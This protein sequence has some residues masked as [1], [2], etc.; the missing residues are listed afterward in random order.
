M[1]PRLNKQI[2][3]IIYPA[4]TILVIGLS[5]LLFVQ[6]VGFVSKKMA[7]IFD[8]DN[9]KIEANLIKVDLENYKIAS[10]RLNLIEPKP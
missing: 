4:I 1:N 7:E 9:M 2:K 6:S 8:V 5:A 3:K 10:E